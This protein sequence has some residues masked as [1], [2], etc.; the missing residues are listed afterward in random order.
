MDKYL[1]IDVH[2]QSC[3][4]AVVSQTGKRLEMD[5]LQ[6]SGSTLIDRIRSISGRKHLCIEEGTQSE[7]LYEIL[8][9]LVDEMVVA[10]PRRNRGNKNDATD[11][12][13]LAEQLRRKTIDVCVYKAPTEYSELR[14]A[15]RAHRMLT[16]DVV[17]IKNR[18]KAIFRSRGVSGTAREI[19]D[20]TTRTEWLAQLPPSHAALATALGEELDVVELQRQKVEA[21]LRREGERHP[22]V[23]RLAT[24]P[25]L[26]MIR[27]AQVVAVVV[28]PHR[29]RTKRQ[30]WSYCG[31][32]IVTRSSADWAPRGEAW[33]RRREKIQTRGLNMNRHPELKAVFKGAAMSVI[34][35]MLQHPLHLDYQRMLA[36]GVKPDL[37]RVTMARRIAAAVLAMWKTEEDYDPEKHQRK[38]TR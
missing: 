38:I 19:Y 21:W 10:V 20:A 17:R 15:V 8:S 7:W 2:T 34:A 16:N 4:L 14:A 1:A 35:K 26:G 22:I 31:L 36:A 6:T 37:A 13:S 27:A 33:V 29:F 25:G 28:T 24:A 12:W 18:V 30:F 5:I 23:H 9:P 32:A 11:A 3:T